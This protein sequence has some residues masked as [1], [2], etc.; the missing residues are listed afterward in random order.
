MEVKADIFRDCLVLVFTDGCLVNILCCNL[1]ASWILSRETGKLI[2][3]RE[4]SWRELP[5][6]SEGWITY[7]SI[8][9]EDF[10]SCV[11]TA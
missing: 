11:N 9:Q 1:Y 2:S 5:L 10:L 3:I 4:D 7:N 8:V 6:I